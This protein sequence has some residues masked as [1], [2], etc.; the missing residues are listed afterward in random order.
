M[1]E[2]FYS[3][4]I[5]NEL[6]NKLSNIAFEPY[7]AS[8]DDN[9]NSLIA[10]FK[11]ILNRHAPMRPMSKKEQRL[12]S[13]PWITPGILNSI[14]TK[15]KLFENYFKSNNP[16]KKKLQEIFEQT[17]SHK[18]SCQTNLLWKFNKI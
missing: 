1:H 11:N 4:R 14:K 6:K 5:L 8:I 13:K 9:V 17:H 7:T 10:I 18:I 3:G 15:N 16:D 12:C 2:K